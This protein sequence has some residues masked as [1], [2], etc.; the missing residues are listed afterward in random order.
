MSAGIPDPSGGLFSGLLPLPYLLSLVLSLALLLLGC[1]LWLLRRRNQKFTVENFELKHQIFQLRSQ[2]RELKEEQENY[3]RYQDLAGV[4]LIVIDQQ[5]KVKRLNRKACELLGFAEDEILGK[6]WFEWFVPEPNRQQTR[7]LYLKAIQDKASLP[8]YH[9]HP[10]RNRLGHQHLIFWHNGLLQDEQGKINGVVSSGLNISERKAMETALQR[11]ERMSRAMLDATK[12]SLILLATDGSIMA[13]NQTAASRLCSSAD[14]LIGQ[15][16]V[17][18]FAPNLAARLQLSLDKVILTGQSSYMEDEDQLHFYSLYFYPVCDADHEVLAVVVFGQDVTERRQ[19]ELQLRQS[20]ERFRRLLAQSPIEIAVGNRQGE[21]EFFNDK[22]LEK[23]GYDLNDVPNMARWWLLAFPEANYRQEA[24]NRWHQAT[25]NHTEWEQGY[26]ICCK[27]GIKRLYYVS[28]RRI[29]DKVIWVCA[30]MTSRHEAE[31]ALKMARDAAEAATRAKSQFLATMSHEIRTPLN[32]ILGFTHLC[33]QTRLSGQQR[34]YLTKIQSSSRSLLDILNSILDFSKIEAGQMELEHQPFD[35]SDLLQQLRDMLHLSASNKALEL[36]ID[37]PPPLPGQPVG[38]ILRLRQVLLNLLSNAIKF[39]ERGHI[40]LRLSLKAISTE[41]CRLEFRVQDSGIGI[42]AEQQQQLFRPFTQADGSIT[43]RYGGT[44]LGL[45][46]SQQLVQC[47]GSKIELTSREGLGSE[48]FF[49]LEFALSQERRTPQNR[50][51]RQPLPPVGKKILV[52]EDQMINQQVIRELLERLALQVTLADNGR[53]ALEKVQSQSFDLV[54]MDI[55]MPELDGMETTR[56][57]RQLPGLQQL[58]VIAMTAHAFEEERQQCLASGMNDHLAKPVDPQLLQRALCRWLPADDS[59]AEL[60]AEQV[61]AVNQV[62]DADPLAES[63][64]TPEPA[65][66]EQ[67]LQQVEQQQAAEL[68]AAELSTV[69]GFNLTEALERVCGEQELLIDLLKLFAQDLPQ[70][71]RR[72]NEFYLAQ[73]WQHLQRE[74]HSL[75][76]VSANLAAYDLQ[77]TAQDLELCLKERGDD[78]DTE[79]SLWQR[80]LW[81]KLQQ[82]LQQ[83]EQSLEVLTRTH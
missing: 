36:L 9:E 51:H 40:Q 6:D 22:W 47:M 63:V 30:D 21:L 4:I 16:L 20:Q 83:A 71:R 29:D 66:S 34:D 33:L 64:Q 81:H 5:G 37:P 44:G 75:K 59:Q 10:I 43:R 24:M 31:L 27:D 72:L 53:I 7:E 73:D 41:Q 57:L 70:I 11:S 49:E 74:C 50:E 80:L 54:L 67:L 48:F 1:G 69:D 14:D 28:T 8:E 15:S 35:L 13:I 25:V 38:D 56:Q 3:R 78:T 17:E 46:I 60:P 26:W 62:E 23:I 42:N 58:P 19:F 76:G 18:L 77:R 45:T 2:Q 12:E 82:A 61:M 32:G 39:T 65:I 55:Q 52:V 68:A 79:E